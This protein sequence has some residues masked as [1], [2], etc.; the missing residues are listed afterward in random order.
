MLCI[1]NVLER[2]LEFT[3]SNTT[4]V[5]LTDQMVMTIDFQGLLKQARADRQREKEGK[6]IIPKRISPQLVW[7]LIMRS[8]GYECGNKHNNVNE[9]NNRNSDGNT[10]IS[11]ALCYTTTRIRLPDIQQI[12][13]RPPRSVMIILDLPRQRRPCP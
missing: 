12:P 5:A 9:N 2:R 1:T 10:G 7:N 8:R 4:I 11:Y 13:P 3:I 6:M